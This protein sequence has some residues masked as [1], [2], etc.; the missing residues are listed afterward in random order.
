MGRTR[1][2]SGH[3]WP[4]RQ[5]T[6]RPCQILTN[7]VIRGSRAYQG[8]NHD[9]VVRIKLLPTTVRRHRGSLSGARRA[10]VRSKPPSRA[11]NG[12]T[13]ARVF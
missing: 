7:F 6:G 11:R 2:K 9:R 1:H 12:A 4:A 8:R 5:K 13:H 3:A 10:P